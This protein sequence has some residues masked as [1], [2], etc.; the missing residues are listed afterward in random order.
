MKVFLPLQAQK[1][2]VSFRQRAIMA[3]T[4]PVIWSG[5]INLASWRGWPRKLPPSSQQIQPVLMTA[6]QTIR[7]TWPLQVGLRDQS[8]RALNFCASISLV[9]CLDSRIWLT[10]PTLPT[11]TTIISKLSFMI[12]VLKLNGDNSLSHPPVMVMSTYNSE[13]N[14]IR[15]NYL[16]FLTSLMIPMMALTGQINITQML[17][18]RLMIHLNLVAYYSIQI[19]R[20]HGSHLT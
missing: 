15:V 4:D 1:V 20:Y 3:A 8:S 14:V 11:S 19:R 16:P 9:P 12:F 10:L 17:T 18:R 5:P 6:T 7:L 13:K 2:S